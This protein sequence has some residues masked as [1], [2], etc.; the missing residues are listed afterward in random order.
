MSVTYRF[1]CNRGISFVILLIASTFYVTKDN[2][3]KSFIILKYVPNINNVSI[4]LFG[5][6]KSLIIL[7]AIYNAISE[8]IL[9]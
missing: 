1:A 3:I 8:S 4:I 6:A 2:E 9:S 5:P 7:T